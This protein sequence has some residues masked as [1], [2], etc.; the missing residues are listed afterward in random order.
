ME[1]IQIPLKVLPNQ[2]FDI[3]IESYNL[4]IKLKQLENMMIMDLYNDNELIFR[5]LN[6]KLWYDMLKAFQYKIQGF[7]LVF[8]SKNEKLDKFTYLDFE[9]DVGLYYVI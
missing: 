4:T 1:I 6:C 3:S 8:L 7:S 5:G 9:K 2:S